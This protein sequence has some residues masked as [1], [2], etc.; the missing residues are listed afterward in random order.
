MDADVAEI[1]NTAVDSVRAVHN[2]DEDALYSD[3]EDSNNSEGWYTESVEGNT[4]EDTLIDEA[5][6]G[7]EGDWSDDDPDSE[8]G[9]NLLR[10]QKNRSQR[11]LVKQRF[12]MAKARVSRD[13]KTTTTNWDTMTTEEM[14]LLAMDEEALAKM[15]VDG[16]NFGTYFMRQ[17]V[18]YTTCTDVSC[19]IIHLDPSTQPVRTEGYTGLFSGEYGPTEEVL[20]LADSPLRLFFFSSCLRACGDELQQ[21]ATA[22]TIN[23]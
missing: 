1:N 8:Y 16:W 23:S 4:G 3:E 7:V 9:A 19:C 11:E 12:A 21:R 15:R 17:D 5:E 22:T 14:E 20:E 6:D 18:V 10:L 2:S 13:W